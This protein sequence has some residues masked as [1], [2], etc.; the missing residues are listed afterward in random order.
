[1]GERALCQADVYRSTIH[2]PDAGSTCSS[3]ARWRS[4]YLILQ[5]RSSLGPTRPV[6]YNSGDRRSTR[7]KCA[8]G[9][10]FWE[11]ELFIDPVPGS[12]VIAT[13]SMRTA[14]AGGW[15]ASLGPC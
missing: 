12:V 2:T 8:A 11:A 9:L 10:G 1:M 5:L 15:P 7:V 14:G 4:G 6:P 3:R 13:R